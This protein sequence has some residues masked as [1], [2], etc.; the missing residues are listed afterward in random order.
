[1]KLVAVTGSPHN[2]NSQHLTE[3]VENELRNLG[4]VDI[5]Y[6]NLREMDLKP[7][8]GCFICFQKGEEHCPLKDDHKAIIEKLDSSDGVIFV[9][10]V[11][12]MHVTSLMKR[13]I[14]RSA[15]I[16]HRP[17]FFGKYA[18]A[19]SA[20]GAIGLKEV[21]QYFKMVTLQW[22][23]DYR[24]SVTAQM[25]P[26]MMNIPAGNI[27]LTGNKNIR[28]FYDAAKNKRPRRLTI[29]DYMGFHIMRSVYSLF[30]NISP[31]DYVYWKERGWFDK[32]THFFHKNVRK[33]YAASLLTQIISFAVKISTQK[34]LAGIDTKNKE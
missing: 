28:R 25:P 3:L 34:Y 11:Y 15:Y 12:S 33:N 17:R 18:F 6:I 32:K 24:G 13:F 31:T 22:G 5:E 8:T 4:P 7:C 30:E 9:S 21:T 16:F 29:S 26:T 2:G 14:D 23:F 1:M 27:N 20:T 10:P 19:V